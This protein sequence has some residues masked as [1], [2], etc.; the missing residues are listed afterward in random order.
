MLRKDMGE[1][2]YYLVGA[3]C[4]QAGISRVIYVAKAGSL[5]STYKANECIATG[6][7]GFLNGKHFKWRN[8]ID[9]SL[10]ASDSIISGPIVTVP[11][12]LCETKDWLSRWINATW[13]DCEVVFMAKAAIENN[14]RF[15]FLNIV[16]DNVDQPGEA[17]L[18]DEGSDSILQKRDILY[19]EIRKVLDNF[20]REQ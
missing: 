19:A 20:M 10:L 6:T 11:T 5:S 3:L 14:A 4:S 2:G 8:T 7:E 12:P 9:E 15:S 13:V 17:G 1:T 16:S 18:S